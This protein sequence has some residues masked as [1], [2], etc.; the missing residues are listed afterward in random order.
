MKWLLPILLLATSPFSR[1]ATEIP[2]AHLQ[3]SH[4]DLYVESLDPADTGRMLEELYK[5]LTIFFAKAP[6]EGDLLHVGIYATRER[7]VQALKDDHQ[8]EPT[9]GVAISAGGYYSHGNRKAY[10]FIQPSDYFTRQLILHECVHQFHLI[11]TCGN[12]S[13]S[14]GFYVE[15]LADYLAFHNWDG[16]HLQIAVIPPITLEDYHAKALDHFANKHGRNLQDIISG[17]IPLD[18]PVATALLNFIADTWPTQFPAWR[19]AMDHNADPI[20]SWNTHLAPLTA[21]TANEFE[22]WLESHQEP[23]QIQTISWQPWAKTIEGKTEDNHVGIALLKK[24]PSALT[25]EIE[26]LTPRFMGGLTFGD[27]SPKDYWLFQIRLDGTLGIIQFK[28]GHWQRPLPLNMPPKKS[29]LAL[30][31]TQDKDVITLIANGKTVHTLTAAGQIGLNIQ[32]GQA[33]FKILEPR[34]ATTRSTTQTR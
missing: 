16:Q 17:K 30:S 18:R 7:Y 13:V 10:L 24:T 14:A 3:T 1:A 27:T 4:Y 9:S 15:G 20:E 2:H 8:V 25:V 33:R 23:W 34:S 28:D 12:R 21:K 11:A 6:P 31:L 19:S 32:Y 22:D 5:H 29:P 26:P